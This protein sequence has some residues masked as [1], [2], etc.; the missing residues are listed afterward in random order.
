MSSIY[1]STSAVALKFRQEREQRTVQSA[2]IT[3]HVALFAPLWSEIRADSHSNAELTHSHTAIT[4]QIRMNLFIRDITHSTVDT[5]R[6]SL[7]PRG[8]TTC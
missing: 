8:L 3:M 6:S 5:V 4:A 1:R 7:H 2:Q